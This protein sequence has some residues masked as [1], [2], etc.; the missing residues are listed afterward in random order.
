MPIVTEVGAERRMY[1]PLMAIITLV[2][3]GIQ[4]SRAWRQRIPRAGWALMLAVIAIALGAT[5]I[6]RNRDYASGL[7]LAQSAVRNR[8]SDAGARLPGQ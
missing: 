4:G 3:I 1:L 7:S 6:A 2:V 5:T 8:P